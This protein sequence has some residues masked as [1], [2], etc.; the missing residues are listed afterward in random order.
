[1]ACSVKTIQFDCI[2]GMRA[3]SEEPVSRY[4]CNAKVVTSGSASLKN[5]TGVHEAGKS[6]NDVK[7]LYIVKQD[8]TFFPEG[9]SDFFNNLDSLVIHTSSLTSINANDLKPFPRLVYLETHG[10]N[11]TSIDGDLL[12]FTP[13]LQWVGFGGNQIRHIG[14]DLVA[15][16]NSLTTLYFDRNVCINQYATRS[17]AAVISLAARLSVLCPPLDVSTTAASTTTT[18]KATTS[19]KPTTT[20]TTKLTTTTK[21]PTTTKITSTTKQPTTTK[22]DTTTETTLD[23]CLCDE[24]IKVLNEMNR[25][26]G[27][28][29]DSLNRKTEHQIEENQQQKRDIVELQNLNEQQNEDIKQLQQSLNQETAAFERRLL[30]VEM[31]LRE[32]GSMP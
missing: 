19:T 3:P 32:I 28:R 8:I 24:E 16:L 26:L 5:V 21:Q 13:L 12:T 7:F 23:Q 25:D 31:K 9:I 20:T 17:R 22:S 14:H 29:V 30:E 6:N 11:L 10:N 2:F 18:S 4:A 27:N 1:M 15:N